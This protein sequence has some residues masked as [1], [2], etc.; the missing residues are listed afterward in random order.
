MYRAL[1]GFNVR[2]RVYRVLKG[3]KVFF[4]MCSCFLAQKSGD[5]GKVKGQ[6]NK[7]LR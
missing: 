7:P 3:F 5:R 4:G 1:K 6:N 2:T